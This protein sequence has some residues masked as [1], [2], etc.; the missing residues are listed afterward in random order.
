MSL[1]LLTGST[2]TGKTYHLYKSIIDS[3]IQH[4]GNRHVVLVP[5]QFTMQTQRALVEMHP[6]QSH[7]PGACTQDANFPFCHVLVLRVRAPGRAPVRAAVSMQKIV[8]IF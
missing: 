3:A 6:C 8:P 5:E 1:H 7:A 2:G 4:P